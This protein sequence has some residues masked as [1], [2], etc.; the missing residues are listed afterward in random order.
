MA[1]I[2]KGLNKEQIEAVTNTEG[3]IR[4]IAGAGSGKTRALTHRY[5]FLIEELGLSPEDILCV[6]FTNK[7]AREMKKRIRGM[8]GDINPEQVCT[9]HSF[10]VNILR[11]DIHIINYP[12]N[13]I[14][15]DN[16]DTE[17]ILK[18]VYRELNINTRAMTFK[19]ARDMIAFRKNVHMEHIPYITALDNRSLKEKYVEAEDIKDKIFY[20]YLYEQKKCFGLDYDDLL[21]L[22]LHI[23]RISKE[24]REKWQK[25]LMYIMVDEFQDVSPHQYELAEILSGYHKNLFIVGD[26]DQTIYTWRGADISFILNF[27]EF[28]E[29]TKTIFL[30][31]NYRSTPNILNAANSLIKRNKNRMEKELVPIREKITPVIYNHAKTT[32]EEAKWIAEQ[33]K[34]I[35]PAGGEYKDIAILYRS[36][37]VSRNLEE[38][39]IDEGLPYVL[40]SGVEFYKRKEIKDALSY[41]RMVAHGDDLSFLRIVNEPK[42]NIG[43]K[44]LK[45]LKE[46]SEAH[47]CSLYQALK[48]NLDSSLIKRTDA[49]SFVEVVEKYH[50]KYKEMEVSELFEGILN[51]SGYQELLRTIGE[52]DRLE[53]LAE[54][55]QSIFDYEKTS[56]E[57][58][59]LEDYLEKVALFTNI[60]Q[61]E[62]KS[63][64]KMMTVHSAKGLE[65]P[66][67]FICGLN[68]GIFPTKHASK[69]DRIEEERRL[70][71]VAYT[72]A[73][74]ALFLS[75]AEGVN[76]DGSFRYPSRFIFNTERAYLEYTVELEPDLQE[77]AVYY[78]E[79]TEGGSEKLRNR[80]KAGS[81]V[82]HKH[83]K[84]GTILEVLEDKSSYVIKFD[85]IETP[86]N[87]S[88]KIPLELIKEE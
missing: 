47:S 85:E 9:F 50:D 24:K 17:A 54:L 41:M 65:F 7:A 27:H 79:K 66:Y 58:N 29:G 81:R 33:I 78:I 72:R 46:Y 59:F 52:N 13:F 36:H 88:F 57:E 16:E 86:R 64:I 12:E 84:T 34:R 43:E 37:F 25:R 30:N 11:E 48:D 35:A 38:V 68:E 8:I 26:P 83:F 22:A 74:N 20:G 42:R 18:N 6:T 67:V 60:D 19:N 70:A 73:E 5:A 1:D 23:L 53:N 15:M 49:A 75:D 31:K 14:V 82:E 87:I 44:R 55:K 51:D 76:Y 63:S 40:Y 62:R 21:T 45:L 3:Y 56:G 2:L 69:P 80:L 61:E 32:K 4:V 28:H 71:Y 39:F 77:E 10:C